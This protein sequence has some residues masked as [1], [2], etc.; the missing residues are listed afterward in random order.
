MDHKADE[1]EAAAC[2]LVSLAARQ[3]Y[4]N[5]LYLTDF[6]RNLERPKRGFL[7]KIGN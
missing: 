7:G 3:L 4:K 2:L 5:L 6:G 1:T